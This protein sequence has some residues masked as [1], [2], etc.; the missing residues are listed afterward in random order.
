VIAYRNDPLLGRP[1]GRRHPAYWWAVGFR[2]AALW[3]ALFALLAWGWNLPAWTTLSCAGL[4]L[5]AA[6]VA[7]VLKVV[8]RHAESRST[9]GER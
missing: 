1:I 8:A 3:D 9:E 2:Y 5:I 6:L 7:T 4:A